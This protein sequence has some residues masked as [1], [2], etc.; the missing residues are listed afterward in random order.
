MLP[1]SK[2]TACDLMDSVVV[3]RGRRPSSLH[4]DFFLLCDE[5]EFKSYTSLMI[6]VC[7]EVEVE[8][9]K[10]MRS[11]NQNPSSSRAHQFGS[12]REP[13]LLL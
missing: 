1:A 8:D 12:M 11:C 3:D 13:G 5:L 6:V 10:V 7:V 2:S 9:P 4:F